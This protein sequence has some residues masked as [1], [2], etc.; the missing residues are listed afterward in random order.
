MPTFTG[1]GTDDLWSNPDNWSAQPS[2]EYDIIISSNCEMDEDVEAA[3]IIINNTGTLVVKSGHVLTI[4]DNS[5]KSGNAPEGE[6]VNHGTAANFIIEDGGQLVYNQNGLLGTVQKDISYYTLEGNDGWHLVAYPLVDNGNVS[7]QVNMLSNSYD[8]YYYEEPTHYWRNYK[9][10]GNSFTQLE[11]GEGYLYANSG[12]ITLIGTRVGNGTGTTAYSPFY[13]YYNYSISETLFLATELEAAGLSTSPLGSLCWYATNSTGYEQS[14]ISIWMAN[15]SDSELT[16]TSHL[17]DGMTLVY[18]GSMTPVVGWN[19]FVFNENSFSWD[20]T[21]N[22]LVCIQRNNGAYNTSIRWQTHD[23]GFASRSYNYND[24]AAYDVTSETY[25]MTVSTNFRPNT[26]FKTISEVGVVEQTNTLLSFRGELENGAA[27]INIPLSYTETAGNLKGFN[28]VGNPFVHNVTLFV[29]TNVAEECYRMNAAKD[30]LI[31]SE[32]SASK[33]L[34]PAE[35]FFVKATAEGAS[36]TFNAQTR[37]ETKRGGFINLELREVDP[38]TS[39]GTFLIDRLIVKREGEPLEKLT[40]KK[41]GTRIFATNGNQEMAVAVAEG[42]EQPVN[43]KAA[44]NGTY[45]LN[46]NVEGLDLDY[47]HLID[48]LTGENVDLLATPS[49]TF[50]ARKNDYASRF[51]LVFSEDGGSSTGS[52][53]TFFAFIS[54][55]EIVLTNAEAGATLQIVDVMG[56]VVRSTDGACTVSTSGIAPG[57]Y[58]LRLINGDVVRTQKIVID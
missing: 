50:E 4:S 46:A 51:R 36:I 18:T 45:T 25:S 15:V 58:V 17:T 40:L 3:S 13:T 19:E 30:N 6:I 27:T 44:K 12:T 54:N 10:E 8:L 9:D 53:T 43:F 26:I 16:E 42:N 29:R 33:P 57:V 48:N 21:S 5:S 2:N 32:V 20:G 35:G 38:S 14:G 1:N 47:L 41:N 23:P 24:D 55:G 37:G 56:R 31:V 34:K 52:E 7:S 28:L 22:V 49:Y 11:A 39:S